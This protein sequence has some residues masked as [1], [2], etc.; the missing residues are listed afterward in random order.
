MYNNNKKIVNKIGDQDLG[1]T[2][3]IFHRYNF[4]LSCHVKCDDSLVL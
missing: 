3:P 1:K 4:T 2:S